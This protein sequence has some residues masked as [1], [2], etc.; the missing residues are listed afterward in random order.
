MILLTDAA[1]CKEVIA[2]ATDNRWKLSIDRIVTNGR[3]PKYSEIHLTQCRSVALFAAN[4]FVYTPLGV[5][6]D[7]CPKKLATEHC[8]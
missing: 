7:L 5:N 4:G 1:I 6:P 8:L 3:K 2:R